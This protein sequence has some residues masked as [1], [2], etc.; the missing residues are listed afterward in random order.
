MNDITV[1]SHVARDLLQSAAMF[2][3]ERQAVW[4]YVSNS[5]QYV[6][7]KTSP[8]VI[9][10]LDSRAKSITIIDNGRGMEWSDLQ[11]Y[12]VMH[13]EN[14]DRKQGRSGRGMF[15]TGKSAAFGIGK[16][17][18]ITT[19]RNGKE[20]AVEL[21]RQDLDA[22][23]SGDPV[24]VKTL[25]REQ[26]TSKPNGTQVVIDGISLKTIDQS[27][28]IELIERHLS[29]WPKDV[30]VTVN[31][32]VCEFLEPPIDR[33]L[34][35]DADGATAKVLGEATLIVKVSKSPL[36]ADTRGISILSK[37][38]WHETT[39][40]ASDGKDMAEYIF[41]EIDVPALEDDTSVPSAFDASRSMKL[42][43]DNTIVA[44]IFAF[45]APLIESVRKQLQEEHKQARATEESKRLKDEASKI[46]D[47]I[48]SDFNA[49]RSKLQKSKAVA[50]GTGFDVGTSPASSG[51]KGEDDDFISGGDDPASILEET[52]EP[53]T[54]P[55]EGP[56]DTTPGT[57]PRRLNPIVKPDEEGVE[58]GHSE[59]T[60]QK[61]RRRG[62]FQIE[63]E[64]LGAESPRAEYRSESRTIFVNLDHPQIAAAKEGRA[65]EDPV[66]RRLAYEVAF[67]EY[68]VALA[69]EMNNGGN[70]IDPFDPIYDIRESINRVARQSAGLYS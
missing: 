30:S 19:C 8:A 56:I 35:F 64:Y 38:V 41:G 48:N 46:E 4:E 44:A 55:I 65:A 24:P 39:L 7:P 60:G 67:T 12:F 49:F 63:F 34:T 59:G 16:R 25:L 27:G 37:G 51:P 17:L 23:Q 53:G 69:S 15:G 42:N 28:V 70:Y 40:L 32:H 6:D 1:Q 20:S 3:N 45:V 5:L 33:V 62:G 66:F 10:K 14:V 21:T 68:A 50:A 54:E 9:V 13:A 52:G 11:N 58:T 47:I 61:P 29:K 43:P 22:A 18:H 31:N 26:P 2:K 57:E 36:D